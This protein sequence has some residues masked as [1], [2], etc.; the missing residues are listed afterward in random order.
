M[1]R[2]VGQRRKFLQETLQRAKDSVK[3]FGEITT[4]SEIEDELVKCSVFKHS[5][6]C[7]LRQHCDKRTRD[8]AGNC[9]G[10]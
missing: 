9:A 6:T 10:R 8:C 4:L 1:L 7:C 2:F 3:F 5:E